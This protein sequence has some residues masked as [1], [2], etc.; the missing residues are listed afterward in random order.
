[1]DNQG[2][3]L[4]VPDLYETIACWAHARRKIHDVHIRT[5]SDNTRSPQTDWSALQPR[6]R[7]ARHVSI[8]AA[9]RAKA[10][11]KALTGSAG[12]LVAG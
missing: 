5:P 11:G 6:S 3:K 1:M 2:L 8:T 10:T 9:G 4:R 7:V 12:D